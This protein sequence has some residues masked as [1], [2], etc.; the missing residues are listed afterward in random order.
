MESITRAFDHQ[1]YC[2]LVE[3]EGERF[4]AAAALADATATVPSCPDWT[5]HELVQHMGGVHRWAGEHVRRMSQ[6]RLRSDELDL[7][8]L[9]GPSDYERWLREGI[10][11]LLDAFRSGD[12]DAEVWGWGADKHVRFWPRR[13]LHETTIHRADLEITNGTEPHIDPSVA[14]DGIDEFF[15][16]LPHARRFRP[17]VMKLRGEGEALEFR[18]QDVDVAWTIRLAQ[19]G[20]E[21]MRDAADDARVTVQAPVTPLLLHIYGRETD[22]SRAVSVEGDTELLEFWRTNSAL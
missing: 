2:N 7:G 5:V 3:A 16:N 20:F 22:A 17:E 21:W 6:V 14:T 18:A 9:E 10:G 19:E 4:I 13:M 1:T 8:H 11:R 15:E 12:P